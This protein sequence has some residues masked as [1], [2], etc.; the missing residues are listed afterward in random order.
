MHDASLEILFERFYSAKV[1]EGRAKRTLEQYKA[2]FSLFLSYLDEKGIPK[3]YL[4]L[5]LM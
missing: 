4:K 5:Q 3:I 1:A 2:N